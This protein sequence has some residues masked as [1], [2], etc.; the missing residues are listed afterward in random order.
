MSN[1]RTFL[2]ITFFVIVVVLPLATIA[3]AQNTTIQS[4]SKAKKLAVQVYAGHAITFY[5]GCKYTGKVIDHASCGYQIKKNAKRAKRL[6]WEHV[7]PAHAFGQ[8]FKEW[9]NGHPKC[10]NKKGK[11]FK[12][13]N[14]ARKMA[15]PFRYMEAD[16]YNLYP[17][18][19]EVN[20]LRSNYSMAMIPRE[21]R[22][23]GTCDVEIEDKKVEPRPDIR[24]D[25]AR[26]YMYMDKV[27]I[28]AEVLSH[29]TTANCLRHG[30]SKT[31]LIIGSVSVR[32]ELS[33]LRVM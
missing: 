6:G 7:V 13:R 8:S 3:L 23:F 15:T 16:L 12:G 30:I 17:A 9:R 11:P 18:I 33:P 10:V 28:P 4:F 5:C 26:T 32:S 24:V 14:C 31:R 19:G 21:K 1:T 29:A 22:E 25:I 20:G 27:F 2:I